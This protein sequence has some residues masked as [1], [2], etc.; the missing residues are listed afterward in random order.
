MGL[1]WLMGLAPLAFFATIDA[2]T[3]VTGPTLSVSDFFT[4]TGGHT[5]SE[6][7][8]STTRFLRA[9]AED[10]DDDINNNDEKRAGLS[11][12]IAEKAK[13]LFS[14]S[15]VTPERLQKWL[16]EGKTPDTVFARMR[17]DK[18]GEFLLFRPQFTD[19]LKYIDDLSAKNPTKGTSA[20]ST[21]TARYSD[22]ALYK[23]IEDSAKFADTNDLATKLQKELGQYWI[24]TAKSPD[25]VFHAMNPGKIEHNILSNREFTT[26]AKYADDFNAKYP[27][28]PVSMAPALRKYYS[29]GALFK[30]T[31]EM[32]SAGEFKSVATKIQDE[33][34][35]LWLSSKK[36][37]DDA[38]VELG[39]G[40]TV[41]ALMESPLFSNWL[42]YTNVY[43]TKYPQEKST[44]I[45]A[46][47][48]TFGDIDVARMLQEAKTTDATR[49]IAKQLESAQLEMWWSSGKKV[50]DVFELLDLRKYSH[51]T[52][53]P[54]LNTWVSYIDRILKEDPDRAT[55]LLNTLALRFSDKA[56]NQFLRA[57]MKFP[58]MEKAATTIQTEKIYGYLMNNQSPQR[59]FKWLNV[60]SVGDNHLSDPLFTKWMK[61]VKDF[62]QKNPK[63]QESWLRPIRVENNPKP[64]KQMIKTAMNDPSTVEIAKL[65]ERERF[66]HWLDEKDPPRHVFHFLD[67]DKIGEKLLPVLI[68]KYG[69]SI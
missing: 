26:W 34:S 36:T 63:F 44:V 14:S 51:F 49:T 18:A 62:N 31:D 50:D 1:L 52:G 6:T 54:L 21:L 12:P 43:S 42:K 9:G 30:M 22:A 20:F 5:A 29:D 23:M 13:T 45:G 37:P 55:R 17:L 65:M 47:T 41:D 8:I 15:K 32:I 39:L 60:D 11:V 64:V 4:W 19:W 35:H 58:S 40:R 53:N 27:G 56:L 10:D 68:S 28:Q 24:A 46:L 7:G 33:L 16:A 59:V 2:E 57:A 25:D 69:P 61:Y 48:R 66:N 3:S 38:L 67:L